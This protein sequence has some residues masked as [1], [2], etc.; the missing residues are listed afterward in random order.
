MYM[1]YNVD[2]LYILFHIYV[3]SNIF[4][5][6]ETL[7]PVSSNVAFL[8]LNVDIIICSNKEND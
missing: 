7:Y 3:F 2:S 6:I 5:P 8:L 1:E 4:I